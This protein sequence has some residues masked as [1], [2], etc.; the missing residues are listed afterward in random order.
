MAMNL[1]WSNRRQPAVDQ[2]DRDTLPQGKDAFLSALRNAIAPVYQ[3][4]VGVFT[5][6]NIPS[7]IADLRCLCAGMFPGEE[8][9]LCVN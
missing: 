2:I 5:D 7:D 8:V 4:K 1:T 6:M 9:R 3:T